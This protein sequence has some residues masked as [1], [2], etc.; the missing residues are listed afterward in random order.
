[1]RADRILNR[2]FT[3]ALELRGTMNEPIRDVREVTFS[4]WVDREYE[5]GPNRPACVG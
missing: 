2:I 1:M 4:L 3:L 5:V